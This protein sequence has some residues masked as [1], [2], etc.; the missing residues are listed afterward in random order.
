MI[1]NL[2]HISQILT[3]CQAL[4]RR[5]RLFI[6]SSLQ[7][8]EELG[9]YYPHFPGE[10][11][12]DGSGLLSITHLGK[13]PGDLESITK[14]CGLTRLKW[15]RSPVQD[16]ALVFSTGISTKPLP[17]NTFWY[18]HSK[19]PGALSNLGKASCLH[20]LNYLPLF[21]HIIQTHCF[22]PNNK[23]CYRERRQ[24]VPLEPH[25]SEVKGFGPR[26]G[27]PIH[28]WVK[29]VKQ[30]RKIFFSLILSWILRGCFSTI[31]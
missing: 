11:W 26:R 10:K 7:L 29:L 14:G 31:S 13:S 24:Q 25:P 22:E 30:K 6:E 3:M 20:C 5:P 18:P 2:S 9:L 17:T 28:W 21:T 4:S 1:I 12:A 27:T 23:E 8:S 16:R 19:E 15:P